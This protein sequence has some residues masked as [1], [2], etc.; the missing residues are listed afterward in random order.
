MS[1]R[2]ADIVTSR[3]VLIPLTQ[4]SVL[5]EQAAG[6]DYYRFGQTISCNIHPEWPPIHWEPH[7]FEFFLKQFHE[8]PDQLGWNRYVAM[9]QP[10]GTRTLIGTLGAFAKDDAP[11]TCEIGYSI[12]KRNPWLPVLLFPRA[13]A[14]FER[15]GSIPIQESYERLLALGGGSRR[16]GSPR[17]PDLSEG[18]GN[19]Q[20]QVSRL[21]RLEDIY[22]EVRDEIDGIYLE[23]GDSGKVTEAG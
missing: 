5:I 3:L 22:S 17:Q 13:G 18:I 6:G 10:D 2:P 1:S 11:D 20:R 7:V 8:H 19:C 15:H 4:E 21:L 14:E 23:L 16:M 12:R 9:P